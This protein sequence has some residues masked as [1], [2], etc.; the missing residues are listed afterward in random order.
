MNRLHLLWKNFKVLKNRRGN[1]LWKILNPIISTDLFIFRAKAHPFIS[2]CPTKA[3]AGLH[4]FVTPINLDSAVLSWP[5]PIIVHWRVTC[6]HLQLPTPQLDD[7][8]SSWEFVGEKA[9]FYPRESISLYHPSECRLSPSLDDS[10][11]P[12]V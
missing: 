12:D 10:P 7:S 1:G 9:A 4:L 6:A 11:S 5:F 8:K 2:P 3:P